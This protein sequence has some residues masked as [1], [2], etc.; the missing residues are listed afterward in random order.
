M[1]G[2][3]AFEPPAPPRAWPMVRAM[4]GV[5]L[6]C[7]ALIVTVFQVTRPVIERKRAEDL[8][9]A[10]FQ[11]L[12]E[13]RSSVAF[14]L[15]SDDRFEAAEGDA[16]SSPDVH[17]CYDAEGRLVGFAIEAR[18][19]GYQDVIRLL[20]GYAFGRDAIVGIRVLESRET[21]GLGDRIETD[22]DFLANFARLDV[23]LSEDRARV[24]HPIEP[25][26]HGAREQAWQVDAIT[27]ATISSFA[28]ADMLRESTSF[29]IPRIRRNLD[30]FH[31]S[32]EE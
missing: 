25:V 9:R 15:V 29:W 23:S 10:I 30:D 22:P 11:V 16:G 14:R 18:G 7:G 4:V 13:A 19:M 31:T 32:E 24:L 21:P 6:A 1:S 26:K 8:R 12:P 3:L 5:G 2:S 27:G 17:A 20:Y 28:V